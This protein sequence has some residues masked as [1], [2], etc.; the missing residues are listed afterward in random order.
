MT[1]EGFS[2]ALACWAAFE[3]Y[4]DRIYT[5]TVLGL[6]SIVVMLMAP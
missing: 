2:I 5:G 1:M 6:V 3:A 4:S